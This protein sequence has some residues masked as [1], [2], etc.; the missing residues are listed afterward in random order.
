MIILI[1]H[2]GDEDNEIHYITAEK[3]LSKIGIYC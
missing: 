2:I 1:K 3:N